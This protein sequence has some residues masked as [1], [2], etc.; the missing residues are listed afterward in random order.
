MDCAWLMRSNKSFCTNWS[1]AKAFKIKANLIIWLHFEHRRPGYEW[2]SALGMSSG[3]FK[4]NTS[5]DIYFT[6]RLFVAS[7][8]EFNSVSLSST[9]QS[10]RMVVIQRHRPVLN[11]EI[12]HLCQRLRETHGPETLRVDSCHEKILM[13][14]NR[15][16]DS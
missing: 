5:R 15:V 6:Q 8:A 16:D 9:S 4:A 11:L 12:G 7:R 1:C 14:I 13:Q 3:S 10:C 2:R